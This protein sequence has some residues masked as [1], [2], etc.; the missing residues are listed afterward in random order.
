VVS[1]KRIGVFCGLSQAKGQSYQAAA[2]RVG[3]VL[4]QRGLQVIYGGSGKG[5]M[6]DLADAALAAGGSVIG[7]IPRILVDREQAHRGLTQLHF[8]ESLNE[9][10]TKI[11]ELADAF[12]ALPGG[13]GTL[14]TML[15]MLTWSQLNIHQKPCGFLNVDSFYS[16]FAEFLDIVRNEGFVDERVRS[17]V[18]VAERIEDL[19]EQFEAAAG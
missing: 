19:L 7:V 2:Q 15:E 1:I 12:I 9:R 18:F 4:A 13:L 3:S 6:R 11:A 8:V 17:R 5:T 10:K 14:D 16:K